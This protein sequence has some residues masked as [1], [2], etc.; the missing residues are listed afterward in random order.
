MTV[1]GFY[2]EPLLYDVLHSAGI[3]DEVA[4]LRT[5]ARRFDLDPRGPWLEPACGSGRYVR[6]AIAL[7]VRIAAFDASEPMIAYVRRRLRGVDPG[8]FRLGVAHMEGF[9]PRALAPSWTFE[10]AFN[11]INTI[12][13]LPDDKAVLAH[14]ELVHRSLRP[15]GVYAVGLSTSLY[16]HE[17]PSEDVW[18]GAR[19]RLV[20]R[21]VVQYTPPSDAFDR[22]EQVNSVLHVSRPS[23]SQ[24]VPSS[25]AL[26]CYSIDQWMR[27]IERSPFQ[28]AGCVD[29]AGHTIDPPTL[30]YA[31]WL[32]RR[33]EG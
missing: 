3:A 28:L 32:L 9:D 1:R 20:V 18:E 12:R 33:D 16:G 6:A 17:H 19:G 11:P 2:D 22:F 14:L 5:I 25:Y 23:G 26:R 21:Q 30:G 24:L 27:E 29:E 7:G 4:G 10:L 8:L 13:H 31:L 15:G